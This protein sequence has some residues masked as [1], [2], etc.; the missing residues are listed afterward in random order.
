MTTKVKPPT[1]ELRR[2]ARPTPSQLDHLATADHVE[3]RRQAAEL[4]PLPIVHERDAD[5]Y[6]TDVDMQPTRPLDSRFDGSDHD[7]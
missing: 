4:L 7:A 1:D 3:R 6:D 2:A 5:D